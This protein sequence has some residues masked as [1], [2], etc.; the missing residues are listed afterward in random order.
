MARQGINLELPKEQ[1]TTKRRRILINMRGSI[2]DQEAI[3]AVQ[4]VI[5]KGK[6]VVAAKDP[7]HYSRNTVMEN[8]VVVQVTPNYRS[9][10]EIFTVSR[11]DDIEVVYYIL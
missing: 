5:S 7:E 10:S 2:T 8:G 1:R 4:Q 6:T 11:E 9:R 3:D